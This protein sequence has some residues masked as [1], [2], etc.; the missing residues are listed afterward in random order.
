MLQSF[1][2][3]VVQLAVAMNMSDDIETFERRFVRQVGLRKSLVEDSDGDCIFLDPDTRGCMVY[4][5]RPIQCRTWPFWD[6]NL[7][8]ASTW[9]KAAEN[10]PGCNRGKIYPFEAIEDARQKKAI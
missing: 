5:A 7:E 1:N 6:R 2:D 3:N 10:C 8:T 4:H 9:E